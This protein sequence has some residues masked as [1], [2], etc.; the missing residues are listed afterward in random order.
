MSARLI[1]FASTLLLATVVLGAAKLAELR[2]TPADVD[3]MQA[4]DAGAGTSGVSGIRTTLVEGDPTQAGRYTIRLSVPANTRIQAHTHH[5]SRSAV[6]VAG[7]WYFGYGSVASSAA[8]RALP[9]GSFYT[10]P[11]GVAHFAETKDTLVVVYIT[12]FGP[13][14]TVYVK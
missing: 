13:T 3:A 6:V 5:D 7:T 4:H 8:T 2:V 11:A 14:D 10:E 12:G 9:A 1:A